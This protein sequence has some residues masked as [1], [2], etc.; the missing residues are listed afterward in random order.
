MVE[1]KNH[2]ESLVHATEKNLAEYGDKV[3][4]DEKSA[5]EN[6]VKDLK[7]AL[8]GEDEEA[9]KAKTQALMEASM[10]LGEAIYKAQQAESAATSAAS[11][12][13]QQAK[14]AEGEVVDADYEEV[15][16]DKQNKA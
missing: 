15:K 16:D 13:P 10:K 12:E 14:Q 6:A 7:D 8:A 5:I 1:A 9:I 4:A 2:A 3:S 11:G